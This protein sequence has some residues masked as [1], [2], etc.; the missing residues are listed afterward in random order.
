MMKEPITIELLNL[1]IGTN[2]VLYITAH[3]S[4]NAKFSKAQRPNM[5][6][7]GSRMKATN[8]KKKADKKAAPN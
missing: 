4:R 3:K 7:I 1:V 8:L 2:G 6:A 5:S